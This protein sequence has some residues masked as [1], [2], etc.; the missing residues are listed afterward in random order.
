M[1]QAHGVDA[2]V[3]LRTTLSYSGARLEL[4]PRLSLEPS[5]SFNAVDPA[6]GSFTT[7]LPPRSP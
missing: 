6:Q 1:S 7:R 5:P 3:G 2:T 4:S